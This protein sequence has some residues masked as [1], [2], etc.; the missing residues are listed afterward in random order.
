MVSTALA[1]EV[2]NSMLGNN[3]S[4]VEI[5]ETASIVNGSIANCDTLEKSLKAFFE[6]RNIDEN[7]ADE[8]AMMRNDSDT[9]RLNAMDI[10]S[11]GA[12]LTIVSATSGP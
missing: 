9:V 6:S 12:E 3:D 10:Y 2:D 1:I 11:A 8:A 4:T 5:G 7:T